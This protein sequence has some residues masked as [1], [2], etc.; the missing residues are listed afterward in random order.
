MKI[1]LWGTY[2]TG[3][4]R[5]RLL[6]E[7]ILKSGVELIE[8]HANIWDGIDDKSQIKGA[9]SWLSVLLRLLSCYP[10]LIWRYLS[11]PPHDLVLVSY[12][13]LL[14]VLLIRCFAWLRRT[15]V[16]WDVFISVYDTVIDDR[17]LF[18]VRHPV[19]YILW[20]FEWLALRAANGVF[21]DTKAHAKRLET[22]FH[23]RDGECGAVWVGAEIEKFPVAQRAV[24][25]TQKSLQILFYGQFIPLHGIEYIVEAARLLS[26][27]EIDWVLIGKGQE[28]SRIRAILD[29]QP[30]PRVRWHEWAEY[31]D[32]TGWIQRADVCLGIFGTSRKAANVIPNKIFQIIAA[33]KPLITQNSPAILELLRHCPPCVSLIPAG[34]AQALADAVRQHA[35]ETSQKAENGCHA[36]LSQKIDAQAIGAQF[37]AWLLRKDNLKIGHDD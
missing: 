33:Q 34:N 19:A 35:A 23:L 25:R 5:V 36:D 8:C 30:L 17:R 26:H 10:R 4:P 20:G 15:P 27:E 29:S 31:Q 22:L 32:L 7:G 18:G 16:A 3:K 6:R 21:M 24:P 12:P 11:L 2:D 37:R 14:D 28:T 13:G 9:F 1:V